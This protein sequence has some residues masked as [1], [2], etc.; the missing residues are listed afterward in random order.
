MSFS[1]FSIHFNRIQLKRPVRYSILSA[2]YLAFYAT[3]DQQWNQ[4]RYFFNLHHILR[5]NI[6]LYLMRR[7][8]PWKGQSLI[9]NYSFN[10]NNNRSTKGQGSKCAE[11]KQLHINQ[12]QIHWLNWT[13]KEFRKNETNEKQQNRKNCWCCTETDKLNSI[14][15]FSHYTSL[16][17]DFLPRESTKNRDFGIFFSIKSAEFAIVFA[18]NPSKERKKIRRAGA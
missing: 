6:D 16:L 17:S 5:R 15:F 2:Y 3:F 1:C 13:S 11:N 10:S 18:N 9:K 4:H 12:N 8:H 14:I 7:G